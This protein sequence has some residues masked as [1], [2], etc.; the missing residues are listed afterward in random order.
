MKTMSCS[1]LGGPCGLE[2]RGKTAN[3]VIKEQDRH[4][5]EADKAGDAAHQEARDEMK[6]RRRQP[7]RAMAWYRAA[8]QAFDELPE[9]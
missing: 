9:D 3:D 8:V 2:H 5:K 4:L 6:H 7:K 1:Q